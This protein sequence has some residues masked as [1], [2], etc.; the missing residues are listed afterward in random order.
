[1]SLNKINDSHYPFVIN[2]SNY[3]NRNINSLLLKF[4]FIT[5]TE[6]V[7]EDYNTSTK[8]EFI[9]ELEMQREIFRASSDKYLEPLVPQFLFAAVYGIS[10]NPYKFLSDLLQNK[11]TNGGMSEDADTIQTLEY[12]IDICT[13]KQSVSIGLIVMENMRDFQTAYSFFR[14]SV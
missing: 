11:I 1:M 9:N 13:T 2:R 14:D 5:E 12:I 7:F 4:V 6:P 8:G 3:A 10:D